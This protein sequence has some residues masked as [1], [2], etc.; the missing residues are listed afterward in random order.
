LLNGA[1][2]VKSAHRRSARDTSHA[3][4]IAWAR[5]ARVRGDRPS[6]AWATL[7]GVRWLRIAAEGTR[8]ARNIRLCGVMP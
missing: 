4:V 3:W 5:G 8:L 1:R 2:V 6:L 7:C